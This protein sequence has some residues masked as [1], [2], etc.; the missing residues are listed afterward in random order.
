MKLKNIIIFFKDLAL[1]I[2]SLIFQRL[3]VL[4]YIVTILLHETNV[5][6]T[7]IF[8]II[9]EQNIENTVIIDSF[10]FQKCCLFLT[11]GDLRPKILIRFTGLSS[12]L[13]ISPRV[14]QLKNANLVPLH[15]LQLSGIDLIYL[16]TT[17]V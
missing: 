15:I 3:K 11:G 1:P 6:L 9:F 7:E 10:I 8:T 16:L 2:K 4:K 5:G 13:S 14:S 17:S 12:P